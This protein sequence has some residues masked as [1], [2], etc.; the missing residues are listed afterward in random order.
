MKQTLASLVFLGLAVAT[1][2]SASARLVECTAGQLKAPKEVDIEDVTLT[3]ENEKFEVSIK[4]QFAGRALKGN[5][6]ELAIKKYS[7]TPVVIDRAGEDIINYTGI[8]EGTPRDFALTLV[9]PALGY[10]KG[11]LVLG[12]TRS[13][14]SWRGNV[15]CQDITGR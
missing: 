1:P 10:G 13:K 14:S 9:Q 6:I 2:Q 11:Y 12:D 3:L 4:A 5:E 15:E 7:M 8:A